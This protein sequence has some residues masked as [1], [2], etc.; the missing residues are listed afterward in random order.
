MTSLRMRRA[1][2]ATWCVPVLVACLVPLLAACAGAAARV[3]LPPKPGAGQPAAAVEAPALSARQQI[4]AAVTGYTT[5]LGEAGQ[6]RSETDARRLL[7][8]YL[9]AA[10]IGG[11]VQAMSGIWARGD[12]F[13]GQDVLHVLSVRIDGRHAFVHDC[14]NTSGMWLE[15]LATGQTVPGSAGIA[16]ANLVTRLDLV[17]G[18]WLVEFQLPEDVPCAP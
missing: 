3:Q 16:H 9:A 11:V 15:D 14:D 4:L 1:V 7:R 12:S 5:A 18:R 17:Q 13:D 8:P 6:S 10:R 2:P